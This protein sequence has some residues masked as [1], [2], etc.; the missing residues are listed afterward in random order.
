MIASAA[1]IAQF[2][3]VVLSKL[4]L[5]GEAVKVCRGILRV[6]RVIDEGAVGIETR[7]NRLRVLSRIDIKDALRGYADL[8]IIGIIRE[9]T[10]AGGAVP[11]INQPI[12]NPEAAAENRFPASEQARRPPIARLR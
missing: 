4:A 12:G 3:K 11:L 5:H 1:G 9:Q 2:E 8:L 6:A 10:H 7:Q